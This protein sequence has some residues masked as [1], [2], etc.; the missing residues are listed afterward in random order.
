MGSE[1]T[2][3]VIEEYGAPFDRAAY[4]AKYA[5]NAFTNAAKTLSDY[6]F[7]RRIGIAEV[8]ERGAASRL[9]AR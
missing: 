1:L 2:E 5:A 4:M 7:T 6:D 3:A 8:I 9:Y